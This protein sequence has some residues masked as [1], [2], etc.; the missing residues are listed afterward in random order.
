MWVFYILSPENIYYSQDDSYHYFKL[1]PS[2]RITYKINDKNSL[3]GYINKRV[4]RP[5]EPELRVFPKYDDPELLKVGN[6][7]LRPQFTNTAE[8]AYKL[9]WKKGSV[10]LSVYYRSIKDPFTRIYSIDTTNNL[11]NIINKI[12][13][14]V[15]SATNRGLELIFNQDIT[16]FWKITLSTNLY[17]NTI[18]AYQDTLLFPYKRS[19][20][21]NKT[22]ENS[23]DIKLINQWN[24][25]TGTQMQVSVL[26]YTPKNI[27]QGKQYARSSIDA[28]I[29]QILLKGNGELTLSF[30]DIFN[31]FGIK[32]KINGEGF[33][34]DYENFYETQILRMGFKYKF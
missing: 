34:L 25:P 15:G 3:S 29:K 11:Y 18:N 20:S 2:V 33:S 7:Y 8:L 10:S 13:H 5:G 12:Y 6:P 28:G 21:I 31:T 14:N 26:Y 22:S 32:Q 1:F 30:T 27:P 16:S 19:F 24:F 4:D 23:S 9:G 17:N